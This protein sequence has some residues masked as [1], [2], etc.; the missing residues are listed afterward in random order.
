MPVFD[1]EEWVATALTS[2]LAQTERDIE[3]ICVDDAS[4]DATREIIE[5]FQA[6]DP[7]IRLIRQPTNRSAFQARR[8]GILAATAPYVLFLDG[9]DELAPRAAETALKLANRTGADV[10]GFGTEVIVPEGVSVGRF[11]AAL[12]PQHTEL[13]DDA[14]APTLFP[15]GQI[16]QGHLWRYLWDVR[17]LHA[18]YDA[19]PAELELYRAN[20]I[21]IA[22]LALTRASHYVSTPERLYRYY[23]RR[24]VS[25]R[26]VTDV[27]AFDFYLGA[28]DSIDAIRPGVE[29]SASRRGDPGPLLDAYR[30][31][32]L[33]IIQ[34][35]LRYCV[36]IDD[37]HLQSECFGRLERKAGA[38][39]VV[40]AAAT[41]YRD[42]LPVLANHGGPA[43]EVDGTVRTVLIVT[44]NLGSGGVQGVVVSQA[45][46]LAEAGFR[47]VVAARTLENAVHDL[48]EGVTL[49]EIAGTTL[50]EKLHSYVEI[51]R[52]HR[53]DIAID[54]W[55]LY[56]DSWPFFTL[57]ARTLGVATIGWLHNFALRPIFDDNTRS[58]HLTTYLPLLAR[59]V[60]LS[61]MDVAFWKL[62]GIERAVYLPNPPSPLLLDLPY[63]TSPRSRTDGPVR[64]VWW[65]RLQQHTKRVRALI[66]VVAELR[67]LGVEAELT[68]IGPD[69]RDLTAEALVEHA[70][71]RGVDGALRAPGPLHGAALLDALEHA[72]L[73][74]CTSAIEGYPLALVE[75]QALGL[76]VAMYEL[77]W[78]SVAAGNDGI[79]AAPQGDAHRLALS[80]AD[81]AGDPERYAQHSAASLAAAH[82]ALSHDFTALY[83]QLLTGN[84]PAA[85]S[86]EPTIQD[87]RVLLDLTIAFQEDVST[88]A[89]RQRERERQEARRL[90][91]RAEAL[92]SQVH[93]PVAVKLIRPMGRAALKLF[94]DLRSAARRFNRWVRGL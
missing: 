52:E 89:R 31:A 92:E 80:I 10:V 14:I 81:L 12:Q 47:V 45:A 91:V 76:P 94:P 21:P 64:L 23:W 51:C 8:A 43:H 7:R 68:V 62:R 15:T 20:D 55:I 63:R 13:I 74:V 42:A 40:L 30:S 16:A 70:R 48:P 88:R 24:G 11:A 17:L 44:G 82:A 2:C 38:T 77:P 61:L 56:D 65:G 54:H 27:D 86:P 73:Y 18:A 93:E 6:S 87:A 32:R 57:A 72:D 37:Q 3:V 4:T 41:F 26:Q 19:V 46:H 67:K 71:E 84:L 53:I 79:L 69:S 5:R 39:D 49:V 59:V 78:L 34:M 29:E 60:V 28:Y 75:A 35:I 33:S 85:H 36:A 1:D 50:P 83:S 25:G 22:F 66:D 90:R 9:D 58:S